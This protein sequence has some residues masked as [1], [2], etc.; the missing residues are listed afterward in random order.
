M[1]FL[2]KKSRKVTSTNL[3]NQKIATMTLTKKDKFNPESTTT[4]GIYFCD[5]YMYS[6]VV[7]DSDVFLK[8]RL[9]SI[10]DNFPVL[11]TLKLI[12]LI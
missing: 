10:L 12:L 4:H 9:L 6:K 3:V 1:G 7:S 8:F 5:G 2:V 11:E